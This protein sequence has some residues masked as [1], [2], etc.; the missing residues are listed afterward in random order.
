[1]NILIIFYL[2]FFLFL[3]KRRFDWALMLIVASLPA[4]LI[5]FNVF[6]LPVTLLEAMIVIIFL[7]WLFFQTNFKD[8]VFKTGRWQK[9]RKDC[10]TILNYPFGWEIILLLIIAL[11]AAAAAGFNKSA[12]GIWKAYFFEP[13]L[14]Y[15]ALFDFLKRDKKGKEK[16]LWALAFSALAASLL[17][18][19]QKASGQLILN[20]F[21]AAAESRRVVSFFGYPN[22]VGLYLGPL[23][24]VMAGWL[25]G[26]LKAGNEKIKNIFIFSVIVLS[27]LSIYFAKSA[28]ALIAVSFAFILFAFF[29]GRTSRWIMAGLI[30]AGGSLAFSFSPA[31]NLAVKY[32]T[33]NDF[34]GQV[35]KTQWAETWEMLK[36]GRII[37]G[38]G[39]ANYQKAVAPYHAG[40]FFYNEN[41]DPDFH[42]Q[43]VFNAE[44]R[45]KVWRP[46]EI[47]L[48]PHNIF[49]NFWS[50]LGLAGLLL[51]LWIIGKYFYLGFKN[52]KIKEVS[53]NLVFGLAG[54]MAV[55]AVH[56]LVDVPYFKNDLA[57]M[58]WVFLAL[59]SY[60]DLRLKAGNK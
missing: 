45:K 59:M 52:S 18:V 22:A 58:F 21:W 27:L 32:L 30:L 41:N 11:I 43:T 29:A 44:F 55:I 16:I 33:L 6:G 4:Y 20:E 50:E 7:V 60:S 57:V 36:D 13:A 49:L 1:M 12:L 17:A 54:A 34:S 3:A 23:V 15:F 10:R 24:L 46:L 38:A 42:R 51:F 8:Y 31:R 53:F 5:R 25:A 9:F 56:G 26:K 2:L 47:Y 28:G 48:Y 37:S 39:L 19:Y 35:R 14:F 40:G